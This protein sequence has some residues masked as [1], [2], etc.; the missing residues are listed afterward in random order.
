MDSPFYTPP[1]GRPSSPAEGA[2]LGPA[3]PVERWAENVARYYNSQHAPDLDHGS[4]SAELS[5]LDSLYQASLQAPH[6]PRVPHSAHPLAAGKPAMAAARK[7]LSGMATPGR[8]KTPTAE[9]ERNAYR[10]PVCASPPTYHHKAASPLARERLHCEDQSYSAENLRRIARSLSGTVV[11]ERPEHLAASHSFEPSVAR[12]AKHADARVPRHTS[13]S[14]HL[15]T[16]HNPLVF[17]ADPQHHHHQHQH[18]HHHHLHPAPT[19]HPS[20]QLLRPAA[21]GPG[22]GHPGDPQK[23]NKLLAVLDG[24]EALPGENYHS[25]ALSYG[26]LPRASRRAASG[27]SLPRDFARA[28]EQQ[29]PPHGHAHYATLAHPRVSAQA[30]RA[31]PYGQPPPPGSHGAR[32]QPLPHYR[33]LPSSHPQ[34]P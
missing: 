2:G 21:M 13:P 22:R 25:V 4:P 19:P 5:E 31:A 32:Q 16:S 27:S 3:M 15:P 11:R 34:Q 26:T 10:A 17:P 1:D 20:Q 28:G 6:V 30:G 29:Q 24:R 33:T 8:S 14:P 23:A 18:H 9:I 7:L 12:T